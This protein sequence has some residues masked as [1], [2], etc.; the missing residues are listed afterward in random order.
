MGGESDKARAS[1]VKLKERGC[2]CGLIWGVSC[3]TADTESDGRTDDMGDP[4][5]EEGAPPVTVD[6]GP[7]TLMAE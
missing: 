4:G 3:P 7:A 1:Y 2:I 6:G 5:V